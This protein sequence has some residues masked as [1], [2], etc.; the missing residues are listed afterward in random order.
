MVHVVDP[1]NFPHLTWVIKRNFVAV[2]VGRRMYGPTPAAITSQMFVFLLLNV[3]HLVA[4][5]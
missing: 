1:V 2:H 4:V 3:L 5:A